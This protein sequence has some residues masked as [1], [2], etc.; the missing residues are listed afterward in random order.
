VTAFGRTSATLLACALAAATAMIAV[1]AASAASTNGPVRPCNGSVELCSK[2]F[3]QVVLPGSHNSMTAADLGWLNPNHDISISKQLR[4]GARAMLIDTYY[5]KPDPTVPFPFKFFT[6]QDR[7]LG[8]ADDQASMYLCHVTCGWG[9]S[10]LIA[11]FRK[12]RDFLL[13]NPREVMLFVNQDNVTPEDFARAVEESGLIDL[14]Y[15]GPTDEWP[16]LAQMIR[17]NQRVVFLAEQQA[18]DVPWYHEAYDGPMQETDYDFP[19][20]ATKWRTDPASPPAP[21]PPPPTFAGVDKLTDPALLARSCD[22]FRGG[23]TGDLFLMNHWVSGGLPLTPL[24]PDPA[25]AEIVNTRQVLVDRARACEEARGKLP[26]VLAV[27]FFGIGDTVG[28][29]RELNGVTAKPFLELSKPRGA[30]VKAG[31]TATFRVGLSNFGPVQATGL[32]VC[33]TVPS[34][35]ARAR[36]CVTAPRVPAGGKATAAVK[37]RTKAAARGRATVRFSVVSA[38][39]TLNTS[40][41]LSVKPAAK[42]R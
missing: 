34:R 11:E 26:T 7:Q 38:G 9:A 25:L 13:A 19:R 12:I 8:S 23:S 35:L 24:A 15:K 40:S 37:V 30:V 5:A 16:T 20:Q 21:P 32:R 42:R 4:Q 33:A 28:A 41:V 3:D 1:P 18:G 10:E 36:T 6:Y 22:A 17:T 14:T 27:D 2:P 39:K 31:R 29:A